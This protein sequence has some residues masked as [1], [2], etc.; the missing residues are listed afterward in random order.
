MFSVNDTFKLLTL[1]RQLVKLTYPTD[2]Q[3]MARLAAHPSTRRSLSKTESQPILSSTADFDA[4]LLEKI[5][6][7]ASVKV[8][9]AEATAFINRL[10]HCQP[11]EFESYDAGYRMVVEV[12]GY[13]DRVTKERNRCSFI[14][15]RPSYKQISDLSAKA[16]APK[17]VKG[18]RQAYGD[19]VATMTIQPQADLFDA[20]LISSEGYDGRTPINH[21]AAVIDHLVEEVLSGFDAE[22][23][24]PEE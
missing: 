24:G 2:A 1:D 11:V 18:T 10:D 23:V 14:L 15:R 21:K 3:W 7:D 9:P 12:F 8:D 22:D 17:L 5:S 4:K 6:Q 16:P 20:L 19:V 13:A